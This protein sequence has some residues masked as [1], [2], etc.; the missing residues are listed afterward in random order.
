MYLCF[1]G[2]NV[3]EAK[4][5]LKESGLPITSANDLEDAARKA[6]ASIQKK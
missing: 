4:R 3:N 2:T 5:I 1:K 6:V